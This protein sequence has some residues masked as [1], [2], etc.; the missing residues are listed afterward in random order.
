MIK[1]LIAI[2]NSLDSKGLKK[3]ADYLDSIITKASGSWNDDD[4]RGPSNDELDEL[5]ME[6]G[7]LEKE[8]EN[9]TAE[10]ILSASMAFIENPAIDEEIRKAFKKT[11]VHT[12]GSA[13]MAQGGLSLGGRIPPGRLEVSPM[14][15]PIAE[16]KKKIN[17]IKNK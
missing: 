10:E 12:I 1:E 14:A 6:E 5:E 7:N 9:I 2:A 17:Q 4:L 16:A 11:V 15:L 8:I 3:E 13:L